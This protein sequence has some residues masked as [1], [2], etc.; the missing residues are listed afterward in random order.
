MNSRSR[1][2]IVACIWA[3]VITALCGLGLFRRSELLLQDELFQKPET[4]PGDIVIIGIDERDIQEFGAYNSWDRSVMARALEALGSD[5]DNLPA[6]VAIDTMYSGYTDFENDQRLAEASSE[7]PNVITATEATF[8]T[9]TTFGS[10]TVV[11]DDFAVLNYEEPYDELKDAS[12]QGH[13]NTMYDNDGVV[14]HALL[15]VEPDGDRVYSMQY[16]AAR[17]YAETKGV[18]IGVPPTDSR[19]LFYV[20]YSARP[21]DFYDG[22]NLSMLINGEVDPS[23][24]AGKLVLIGPYTSGLQDA[25]NT[26]IERGKM[27]F[28]VEYQANVI[29]A[30]LE[31]DYKEEAPDFIQIGILWIVCLGF[32][33]V[34]NNRRLLLSVPA[35]IAGE[36][37]SIGLSVLLYSGGTITHVLWIP[38]AL[39][40][41]FIASVAENYIRAAIAKQN[42]TRTFE[43]Y[44]APNVVGEILKEGTDN[45]KLGGKTVDIAVLFVDIR[46]FTTMSERLSPEEVVHILNQYLS[47]TSACIEKHHG[48]L[49]KFIGDATMAFWGAPIADDDAVYHAAQT[50]LDI[51]SGAEALSAKLKEEINEEIHVGVGV[52]FGP[53]V[54]GNMGSERRMDYTAIGDT[55]NTAARLEANAP[56]S[57]VYISRAVADKLGARM[58]YEPLETPIKLKGKADGFEILKLFGSEG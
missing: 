58:K 4:V 8:G 32:Y 54:V 30:I 29:Q 56:A 36:G 16:E 46:G 21:G 20:S 53:A 19:G 55:V 15:Y 13:I 48:T 17:L 28:G 44:V 6:V 57:T 12:T 31:S 2:L 47:M 24:Y 26:P 9:R 45:L 34:F 22:V 49:D 37:L 41:L 43:R 1:K 38:L 51:V 11:I 39:L 35:L 52:H 25:Y 7:L 23:Y 14:R 33:L 50:A 18:E 42:V 5:P 40:V 27:M 3:T 10:A